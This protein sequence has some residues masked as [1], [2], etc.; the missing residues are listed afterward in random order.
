MKYC[1]E[2]DDAHFYARYAAYPI[3]LAIYVASFVM[4]VRKLKMAWHSSNT[5]CI[6][7]FLINVVFFGTRCVFWLDFAFNY[8]YYVYSFLDFWPHVIQSMAC[9]TMGTSWMLICFKFKSMFQGSYKG[10]IRASIVAGVS[11]ICVFIVAYFVLYVYFGCD[12]SYL[13]ARAYIIVVFSCMIVYL[14]YFGY[15]FIQIIKENLDQIST[16]K[17]RRVWVY[18]MVTCTFRIAV[19]IFNLVSQES[20]VTLNNLSDAAFFSVFLIVDYLLSE[21]LLMYGIT[22]TLTA[23]SGPLDTPVYNQSLNASNLRWSELKD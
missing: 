5:L 22:H 16:V 6:C 12:G 23:H 7:I 8:P 19:N 11:I 20:V 4:S 14:S 1:I 10:V 17:V 21:V 3:L 13:F 2:K 18:A 9:F 15:K